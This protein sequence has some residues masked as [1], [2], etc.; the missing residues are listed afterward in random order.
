MV[1]P[2]SHP[3]LG[4]T[5][6]GWVILRWLF[7]VALVGVTIQG[8]AVLKRIEPQL[9]PVRVIAIDGEVHRH[10]LAVLQETVNAQLDGG[11]VT[12][13]LA[14]VRDAVEAL[15]WVGAVSL[16]RVW[17]ERLQLKVIEH[18]PV[19]RWGDDGLV[20]AA[21]VV[22]RPD[23]ATIPRRLPLLSGP[24]REAARVVVQYQRWRERLAALDLRIAALDLDARGAWRLVLEDGPVLALGTARLD[25]RLARFMHAYPTLRLAGRA[26]VVDLRYANGLAVRWATGESGTRSAAVSAVNDGSRGRS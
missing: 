17:P 24:D 19:A 14:A 7:V 25:E 23:P 15:P 13:D 21:G 11:L 16:R 22:F 18:R 1:A 10:S 5:R 3:M 26:A 8:L 6:R 20:T 9:L 4:G 12:L 2:A